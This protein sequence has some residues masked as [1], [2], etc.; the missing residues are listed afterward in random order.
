MLI[1]LYLAIQNIVIPDIF[2]TFA[3][4]AVSVF[5]YIGIFVILGIAYSL[6]LQSIGY[7]PSRGSSNYS[8]ILAILFSILRILVI[9]GIHLGAWVLRTCQN[10]VRVVF[11][12]LKGSHP[13]A[14]WIVSILV[15]IVLI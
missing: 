8:S 2:G 10:I 12:S 5:N 3:P 7:T 1:L 4:L 13:V 9:A 11:N 15:T 6:L 14:A